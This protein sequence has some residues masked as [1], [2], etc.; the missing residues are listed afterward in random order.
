MDFKFSFTLYIKFNL[1]INM[2][3]QKCTH[4]F[5]FSISLWVGCPKYNCAQF[6]L[7]LWHETYK[8]CVQIIF[9]YLMLH[10]F[11]YNSILFLIFIANTVS[12]L[13]VYWVVPVWSS[14]Y[15]LLKKSLR[16]LFQSRNFHRGPLFKASKILKP[17][18]KAAPKSY[19]FTDKSLKGSLPS[20]CNTWFK[21][22]FQLHSHDTR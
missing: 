17:F 4:P 6:C 11:H 15:I 3:S 16:M 12:V 13:Q 5:I 10:I 2:F 8:N 21:F 1:W 18:H 19:I 7:Y 14:S 22:S 20:F 9:F